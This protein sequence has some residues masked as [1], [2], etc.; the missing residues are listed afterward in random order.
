VQKSPRS[1]PGEKA[2]P[3][4]RQI[5][6]NYVPAFARYAETFCQSLAHLPIDSAPQQ[7]IR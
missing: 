2:I 6:R 5:F 7:R 1:V 4:N 3:E